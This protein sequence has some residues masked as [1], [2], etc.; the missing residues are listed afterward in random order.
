MAVKNNVEEFN[1]KIKR[2]L[3]TEEEIKKS[4]EGLKSLVGRAFVPP[5]ANAE[6]NLAEDS[7]KAAAQQMLRAMRGE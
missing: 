6:K 1:S 3:I 5:L 7:K 4:A 2:V